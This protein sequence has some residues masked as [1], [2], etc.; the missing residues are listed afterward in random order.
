MTDSD[1]VMKN[2]NE[3]EAALSDVGEQIIFYPRSDY[4]DGIHTALLWA[5]GHFRDRHVLVH[6]NPSEKDMDKHL[7]EW[8]DSVVIDRADSPKTKLRVIK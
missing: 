8:L 1:I 3:I 7:L 4:L 2:Y 5:E 6:F